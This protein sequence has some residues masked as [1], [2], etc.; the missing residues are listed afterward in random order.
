MK[1]T[2][3]ISSFIQSQLPDF[4]QQDHSTFQSFLEAYYEWMETSDNPYLKPYDTLTHRDINTSL[5]LFI[6]QLKNELIHL[7][8]KRLNSEID[9]RFL[10][11]NIKQF[12]ESKGTEKSIKFIFRVLFNQ[13]IDIS[14]PKSLM[15]LASDGK[16]I[17]NMSIK[18]TNESGLLNSL[19]GK[20]VYQKKPKSPVPTMKVRP[21]KVSEKKYGEFGFGRVIEVYGIKIFAQIET[22]PVVIVGGTVS[23]YY[24]TLVAGILANFLDNDST[25]FVDDKKVVNNIIDKE[26]SLFIF[27]GKVEEDVIDW[28]E[29]NSQGILYEVL[30][31]RNITIDTLLDTDSGVSN[32]LLEKLY[33]KILDFLLEWGYSQ[34]YSDVFSL[35]NVCN[36]Q[37]S[38]QDS[39][40]CAYDRAGPDV[41]DS[42]G[43]WF[44]PGASRTDDI[45]DSLGAWPMDLDETV[46]SLKYY[47]T[48]GILM[49]MGFYD[50]TDLCDS[51]TNSEWSF[52]DSTTLNA[53]DTLLIDLITN[54]NLPTKLPTSIYRPARTNTDPDIEKETTAFARVTSVQ[55]YKTKPYE[56]NEIFLANIIGDFD[57]NY[58][59]L[60]EDNGIIYEETLFRVFTDIAFSNKGLRYEVDDEIKIIPHDLDFSVGL[61]SAVGSAVTSNISRKSDGVGGKAL[62]NSVGTNGEIKTV[63]ISNFGLKYDEAYHKILVT[64][65]WGVLAEG[66]ILS[67]WVGV[68]EGYWDNDDGKLST[69]K[70]LRDNNRYH[71]FSYVIE[72]LLTLEQ[73]KNAL[74]S[75]VHPS[76]MAVFGDIGISGGDFIKLLTELIVLLE[77]MPL[78]GNYLP[79]TVSTDTNL[80]LWTNGITGREDYTD[81]E[82]DE[83]QQPN[84]DL[85]P[86]GFDPVVGPVSESGST[87]HS[88]GTDGAIDTNVE[89]IFF[90]NI[91]A[92]NDAA[93]I[94]TYW[95]VYPHPYS[96]LIEVGDPDFGDITIDNFIKTKF[97]TLFGPS[98]NGTDTGTA[99]S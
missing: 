95:V 94:N 52:C 14:Y 98:Q 3:K 16:W 66:V 84:V 48:T 45:S 61:Y 18:S 64:S 89:N 10:M 99:L 12:Y 33:N 7:F 2:H 26:V 49:N 80:R 62:V 38:E 15:L 28:D 86:E 77:E 87:A 53:T 31:V 67:D 39:L 88:V 81:V 58:P 32:V 13:E 42:T 79:Y 73:Y 4:I 30:D 83:L 5:D 60:F 24:L 97:S 74:K 65:N 91:P 35:T 25:G 50:Q 78:I 75:L 90:A 29:I 96:R 9:V 69:I 46:P 47:F 22:D 54:Y 21:L 63:R 1:N 82:T 43:Y 36:G 40:K 19:I 76:G 85:Y 56:V 44:D 23:D 70:L 8:P 59:I 55:N 68:Y 51:V 37:Y 72:S 27:A 41:T 6:D 11:K 17:E 92:V 57:G 93:A 20:T 71:E 34:V